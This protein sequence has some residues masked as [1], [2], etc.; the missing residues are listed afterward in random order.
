M[1]SSD[2]LL[3]SKDRVQID[4]PD[5]YKSVSEEVWVDLEQYLF[6]GFLTSSASILGKSFVFKSLNH[7]EIDYISYLRPSKKSAI[8]LQAAFSASFIAHSVF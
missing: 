6:T 4:I 1:P 7:V 3:R 5:L 2:G 8:E